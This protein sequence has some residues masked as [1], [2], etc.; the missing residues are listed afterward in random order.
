MAAL[1][2]L[3]SRLW[4]GLPD[5]L[6]TLTMAALLALSLSQI[7]LISA[8]HRIL[9]D[10]AAIG[11]PLKAGLMLDGFSLLLLLT[12]SLISLFACIYSINYMEHYGAKGSYY[13]LFLLM[14]AGMNG[15]VLT[16]DLFNMYVFLEVAAVAS[17]ALVALG[18]KHDQVEAAIK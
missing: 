12:I 10:A 15:L 18:Q 4:K 2:P 5:I 6:G 9:W 7:R 16:V 17:Y 8:G 14:V 1:M 11:L 3:V 13:A